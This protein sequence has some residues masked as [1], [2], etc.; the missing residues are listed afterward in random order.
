MLTITN[1]YCQSQRII[2]NNSFLVPKKED[3]Y[4]CQPRGRIEDRW[5][6]FKLFPNQKGGR[7]GARGVAA[8]HPKCP[9]RTKAEDPRK[10][11]ET[12]QRRKKTELKKFKRADKTILGIRPGDRATNPVWACRH[13]RP[14]PGSNQIPYPQKQQRMPQ[15]CP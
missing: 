4:P 9:K 7:R 3:E 11:I 12:G 15:L 8:A 6:N 14:A 1:S 5:E 13:P 10:A 2:K